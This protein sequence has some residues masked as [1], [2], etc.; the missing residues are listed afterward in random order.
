MLV[1]VKRSMSAG[2]KITGGIDAG[3]YTLGNTTATTTANITVG[4]QTI[5]VTKPAPAT[6]SDGSSF[7]VAATATSGLPVAITTS[8]VCTGQGNGTATITMTSGFGECSVFYNQAGNMNYNPLIQVQE[9]VNATQKP[10]ITSADKTTFDIGFPG[11]FTITTTGNPATPMIISANGALPAGV[12]FVD[13][14]DGTATLEWHSDSC[15][16]LSH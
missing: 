4:D 11:T 7:D 8:G 2:I 15:R 9:D 1:P 13:N 14:G 16:G 10:S 5:T 6:A 12:T 3:N